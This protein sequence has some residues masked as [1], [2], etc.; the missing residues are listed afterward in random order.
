MLSTVSFNASTPRPRCAQPCGRSAAIIAALPANF[1]V[2]LYAKGTAPHVA[3]Q[4]F[5]GARVL[6]VYDSA[7]PRA[8]L[9]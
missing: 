2:I 1:P 9:K 5:S 7:H 8:H 4:A 3:D 6:S